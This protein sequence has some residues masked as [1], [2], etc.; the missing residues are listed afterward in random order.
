MAEKTEENEGLQALGPVAEEYAGWFG[1]VVLRLF[2]P[3]KFNRLD[4]LGPPQGFSLW[5]DEASASN[6]ID[7]VSLS[8]LKGLHD[9]LNQVASEMVFTALSTQK[10]PSIDAGENLLHLYDE[11]MM[12]LRR[13]ERDST[14]ADSGMDSLTGLRSAQVMYDDLARELERRDR[15]GKPFC[16]VLARI[17]HEVDLRADMEEAQRQDMLRAVAGHV[18]KCIRSFDDAYRLPDGEFVMVLKHTETSGGLAAIARLRG[19]LEK[20]PV[21][22]GLGGDRAFVSLSYCA[23]E[24]MPGDDIS[25]LLDHMRTDLRQYKQNG[26]AALEYVE[27]SPLTRF[28]QEQGNS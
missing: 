26:D 13:L 19:F 23:A 10:K 22:T 15:Q 28:I 20:A 8:S 7:I 5:H 1:Q 27:Q 2:Y 18:K 6:F 12:K 14:L 4:I 16:V 25:L 21:A 9:E 17:D 24:P 11:F 3:E